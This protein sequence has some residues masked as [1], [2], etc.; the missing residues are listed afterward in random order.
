MFDD[1]NEMSDCFENCFSIFNAYRI[2]NL[3]FLLKLFGI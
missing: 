2:K 1:L 3:S